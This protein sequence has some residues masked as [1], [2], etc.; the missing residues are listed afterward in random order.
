MPEIKLKNV[1]K[2][3]RGIEAVHELSLTV[4]N[5]EYFTF[6]GPMESGRT[7]TLML[8]AGLIEPDDGEIYFDRTR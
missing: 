8:I 7:T 6:L 4:D 1:T 5:G 2:K 3:Y